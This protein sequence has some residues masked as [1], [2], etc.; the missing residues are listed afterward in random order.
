MLVALFDNNESELRRGRVGGIGGGGGGGCVCVVVEGG[1]FQSA[2]DSP[3]FQARKGWR[4]G[5]SDSKL[6]WR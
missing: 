6:L 4:D 5:G 2:E 3:P 1:S